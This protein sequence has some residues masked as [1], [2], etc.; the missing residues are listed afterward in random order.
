MY[1]VALVA[2]I[3][4]QNPQFFCWI[5]KRR[6]SI[7]NLKESHLASLEKKTSNEKPKYNLTF[8]K[9]H[10]DMRNPKTVRKKKMQEHHCTGFYIRNP[11][12]YTKKQ[13]QLYIH[14]DK[15]NEWI[16]ISTY[17]NNNQ[18]WPHNKQQGFN[19]TTTW[20]T[21][22]L[23]HMRTTHWRAA[24][25]IAQGYPQRTPHYSNIISP[26]LHTITYL[27][28]GKSCSL[29]VAGV[30]GECFASWNSLE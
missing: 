29:K 27:Y 14:D 8:R 5:K 30:K 1:L 10:Q 25:R 3:L 28:F 9:K 6:M 18:L 22:T 26:I 13:N 21:I 2:F 12:L 23:S 20:L 4:T 24:G 16:F 7:F 19:T 15:K 11:M 17:V